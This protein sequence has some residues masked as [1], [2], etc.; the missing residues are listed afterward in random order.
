MQEMDG[1]IVYGKSKMG[2]NLLDIERVCEYT[3]KGFKQQ[4][5]VLLRGDGWWKPTLLIVTNQ[6][7]GRS[8]GEGG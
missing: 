8:A 6:S 7:A 2:K 5:D 4:K 1:I 3:H